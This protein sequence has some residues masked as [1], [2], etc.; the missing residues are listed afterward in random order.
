MITVTPISG[1]TDNVGLTAT[2]PTGVSVSFSPTTITGGSGTS[3]MT[4]S[5][6]S[7]GVAGT[8]TVTG[9]D[10]GT[11]GAGPHSTSV[12]LT[13]P[14]F[15]FA[16]LAVPGALS[17]PRGGSL[18]S[19]IT[20]TSSANFAGPVTLTAAIT[21]QGT[22]SAGL[23]TNITPSFS[24]ATVNVPAGGKA[25]ANFFATTVKGSA[26]P[27]ATD[28]ATGNYTVTI[29]ATTPGF[30]PRTATITFNVFDFS[31]GPS[32]CSGS[33]S[34]LT[35]PNA[36]FDPVFV[37]GV[38]DTMTI[39]TQ[40]VAQGGSD[41]Q[42]VGLEGG[43]LWLQVNALGGLTTN[44]NNGN[45]IAGLNPQLPGRGAATGVFVPELGFRACLAQTFWA[46]GTQ[47]P[48]SY[49]QAH[50]P[51][52]APGAGLY[53]TVGFNFGCRFDAGAYPNDVANPG[54]PFNNPDFLA[55]TAQALSTTLPGTYSFNICGLSGSLFNCKHY[56]LVIVQAP[57]VHQFAHIGHV[58]LSANGGQAFKLGVSNVD[59]NTIYVQV[60]FSGTGSA[61]DSFTVQTAVV[62]IA[63]FANANN[64][65]VPVALTPKMVGEVF[66]FTTTIAVGISPTALTGVSTLN[67]V[68]STFTVVP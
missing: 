37:G 39:T 47:I 1:F 58:S 19:T 2:A 25:Q 3:T 32:Y 34:I 59:P 52:I 26:F 44:G 45:G 65:A 8:I 63:P 16:V 21:N 64:L 10:L 38:C 49:L 68:S 66:T 43:T 57:F 5:V 46:N 23:T 20:V 14:P 30:T 56:T 18:V 67:A 29:T 36:N 55:V 11:R 6:S 7:S 60:T 22:D 13:I 33:R 54:V 50:G 48:Y 28:T 42:G 9:T 17:I 31:F 15:G 24:P 41:G 61:G 27:S 53:L 35:T 62:S 51:I 4:V 12:S 40:T